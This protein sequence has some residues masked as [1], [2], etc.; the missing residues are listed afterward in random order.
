MTELVELDDAPLSDVEVNK[1]V[2]RI[3]SKPVVEPKAAEEEVAEVEVNEVDEVLVSIAVVER[4][5]IVVEVE[6]KEELEADVSI[7]VL[8]PLSKLEVE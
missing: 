4:D 1:E 6:V 2:V 5:G 3:D 7:A 8:V